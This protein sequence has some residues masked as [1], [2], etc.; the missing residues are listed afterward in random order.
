MRKISLLILLSIFFNT[1]CADLGKRRFANKKNNTIT[2]SKTHKIKVAGT[3]RTYHIYIP[4][5]LKKE[6]LPVVFSFHGFGS[7]AKKQE[8]LSG[9]SK[10]AKKYGFIVV[11]PEGLSNKRGKQYWN[12]QKSQDIKADID[13]VKT[14]LSKLKDEYP[15]RKQKVFATGIS[16]GGGMAHVLAA[17]MADTFTAIAPVS[18]AYYDYDS[19]TPSKP[20]AVLAFHGTKDRIVPYEGR[21]KLPNILKWINYWAKQNKCKSTPDRSDIARGVY[22]QSWN[23]CKANTVLYTIEGKG[24]SW[25]GSDMSRRTTTKKIDATELILKFFSSMS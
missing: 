3:A 9:M 2:L 18:G 23:G 19:H 5:K 16:N 6:T 24:H 20:V 10:Q 4:P 17:R 22:S 25:P 11:Y 21:R 15:L 1:A 13:L 14:I 12:T 7:S 8:Q